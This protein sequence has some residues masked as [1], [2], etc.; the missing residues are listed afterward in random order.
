LR[1]YT[2]RRKASQRVKTVFLRILF[3]LAA[4]ALITGLAVLTGNLLLEKVRRAEELLET[5]VPPSGNAAERPVE[6]E[7]EEND[8]VYST[9][10]VF[11]AG[12]DPSVHST[13]DSRVARVHT[14]SENYDTV[15]VSVTAKT[16]TLLYTSPA[17]TALLGM[18]TGTPDPQYTGLSELCTAAKAQGL[19]TSAVLTS[20]LHRVPDVQTAALTD[21]TLA[22]ELCMLGFD[23]VLLTEL[24]P[25]FSAADT[26]PDS[27]VAVRRYLQSVH[28]GIASLSGTG[29]SLGACLP[30]AVYLEG[31]NAKQVQLLASAVDFL[32]IDLSPFPVR[33]SDSIMTLEQVCQTLAGSF[34]VYNL[35]AVLGTEDT[36][37]L[38]AQANT[39]SRLE[40]TNVQFLTEVTPELLAQTELPPE[41]TRT[42]ETEEAES[43]PVSNPYATVDPDQGT[44]ESETVYRNEDS[45]M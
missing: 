17:L 29:F 12:L 22:A 30:G 28:E 15:S 3:V 23:E 36:V 27:L 42:A 14:V 4:A 7:A 33:S 41:E 16:G 40:I 26:A 2:H 38:A 37:L 24:L 5:G 43:T 35:R 19:R 6:T 32:A 44:T 10:R 21:S 18:P 39:L 31:E 9:L 25:D 1:Y 8:G 11:A 45:W 20:S 13:A 34:Q